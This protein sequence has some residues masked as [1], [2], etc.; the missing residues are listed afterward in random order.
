VEDLHW[1]DYL[2]VTGMALLMW[3]FLSIKI[4]MHEH[5]DRRW[6]VAGIWL[7]GVAELWFAIR[8]GRAAGFSLIAIAGGSTL[9]AAAFLW[10]P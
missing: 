5:D 1:T 3:G 10:Q 7:H 2:A 6:Q 8:H 4:R 9:L